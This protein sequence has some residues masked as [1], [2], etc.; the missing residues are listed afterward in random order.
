MTK[1][2]PKTIILSGYGIN[3]ER[4]TAYAFDHAGAETEIMHLNDIVTNK[5][6]LENCNILVFPGGF[7]MGDDT[8]SGLAYA[9]MIRNH[10]EDE[11]EAFRQRDT[12]ALGICNGFQMMT[13]LGF[14]P[15]STKKY[16]TPETALVFNE[17]ARYRDLWVNL[18]V[19][20]SDCI[21]TR[22]MINMHLPIAHGEGRFYASDDIVAKLKHQSQVVLRYMDSYYIDGPGNPNGSVDCIAGICDPTGRYLGMMPHPERAIVAMQDT[23]YTRIRERRKRIMTILTEPTTNMDLFRNAVSYFQ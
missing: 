6:H 22:S 14:F 12:L 23:R 18:S 10:L 5:Q 7:S 2:G 15:V 4:E 13:H 8:G 21:W 16:G 19:E 1:K 17:N 3:C 20:L 9:N 11:L